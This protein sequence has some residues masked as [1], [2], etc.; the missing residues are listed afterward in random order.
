MRAD[1]RM[2]E[3]MKVVVLGAG[4]LG[5]V[6]GGQLAAAGNEVTLVG[7]QA[8]VDAV[9]REGLTL[10]YPDGSGRTVRLEAA[11]SP[12]EAGI[13][14]LVIVLSKS[15]DTEAVVREALDCVGVD[16][17]VMSLQNGLGAET[18]LCDLVGPSHVIAGKTYVGGM[19]L[20]P[21]KTQATVQGKATVIGELDGS[22]TPRIMAVAEAFDKAG[23][24][25]TVSDNIMGVTWDKLLVN[26]ATGAV[27][28][29]TGLP[30]GDFYDDPALLAVSESAVQEAIDVAR[31]LGIRLTERTPHEVLE[32][33]RENLPRDFKPSIL[34]SLEKR[35]PTEVGVINGAVAREGDGCGVPTP[36]NHALTALVKGI[37]LRMCK[38]A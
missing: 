6:F 33:A 21:G 4:S 31:A 16:T 24:A 18:V 22:V 19:L 34:Q 2:G 38:D 7:R 15:F 27:C 14:D 10:T 37:E 28:G 9:N 25:T 23:I 35:R 12:A 29:I 20:E 1:R 26:V 5:S 36:V 30:Y 11:T 3:T 32:L 8:H 17:M 13:A